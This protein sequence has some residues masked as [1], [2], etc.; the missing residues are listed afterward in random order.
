MRPGN[1]ER[2][3][4]L[5]PAPRG[6]G[7]LTSGSVPAFTGRSPAALDALHVWY[8]YD[9]PLPSPLAAPIQI[10]NT[11]RALAAAGVTTDVLM[12]ELGAAP[13]TCLHAYGLA[14][15]PNLTLRPFFAG[16]LG[17]TFLGWRLD[18]ALARQGAARPQVVLSRGEP[19]VRV[20]PFMS[21][22]R[23]RGVAFV[24][25]AHRLCF[26]HLAERL[27]GEPWTENAP[28]PDPA[29]RLRERERAAI[30]G[31]DGIVC[32]TE[33][34]REAV[35]RAFRLT[36][37]I[38]ILPS[39]MSVPAAAAAHPEGERDIDVLYVGKLTVRKGVLHSIAAV[40]HLP[41]R[42][43]SVV[44]GTP[45]EVA[46]CRAHARSLGVEERIE[47]AGFVEP[48]R[49]PTYLARAK[50][51]VCPLPAGCSITSERFTSPM[52][53]LEMMAHGLPV[54]ATDLPATRAIVTA[55]ENALLVPPNDPR[56][57]ARGIETLLRDPALARRIGMAA[58][59]RAAE[60]SWEKRA[61]RLRAFLEQLVA[62]RGETGRAADPRSLGA[63]R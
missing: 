47:F 40:R 42:R 51:G 44:G 9:L 37:P 33:G 3:A 19:G 58:R 50:V 15:H 30:E 54:V 13:A 56:A 48:R 22:P 24:Y 12:G 31:A 60:F 36:Q 57:L 29:R 43:M 8:L 27:T 28:L 18:H 39:G 21:G 35:A 7:R 16:P 63:L 59:I 52:K 4:L 17:W 49:V 34:V 2:Q 38:L 1:A 26:A 23:S 45:D 10:L 20:A 25:E 41:G 53:L 14:P 11:C 62:D 61:G 32:L 55:G 5:E 6:R 46:A